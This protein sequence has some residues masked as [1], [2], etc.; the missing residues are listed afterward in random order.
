MQRTYEGSDLVNPFTEGAL[1]CS[2]GGD[3]AGFANAE[4]EYEEL[5]VLRSLPLFELRER[6]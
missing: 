6:I 3:I 1:A 4:I 2:H 5:V